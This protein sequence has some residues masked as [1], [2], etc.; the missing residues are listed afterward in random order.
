MCCDFIPLP[1]NVLTIVG[2]LQWQK[3]IFK[4]KFVI[5]TTSSSIITTTTT[6]ALIIT[7]TTITTTTITTSTTTI[8]TSTTTTMITTST[9]TT[10]ITTST[11]TTT[12]TTTTTTTTIT[13]STTTTITTIRTTTI[14]T[15]IIK[16]ITTITVFIFFCLLFSKMSFYFKTFTSKGFINILYQ[17]SILPLTNKPTRVTHQTETLINNIFANNFSKYNTQS[18]II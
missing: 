3:A 6:T 10:T 18:G 7:L 13:T 15:A 1:K 14:T 12:I 16:Q 17:D 11:T 4:M 9:T 2:V 5:T 8:T